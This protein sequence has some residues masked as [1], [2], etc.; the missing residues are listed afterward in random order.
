MHILPDKDTLSQ[1]IKKPLPVN[2][3]VEKLKEKGLRIDNDSKAEKILLST[4]YYYFTGYLIKSKKTRTDC[5]E[6]YDTDLDFDDVYSLIKFD[7]QLRCIF[8]QAIDYI[9]RDI[10]TKIAYYM[11]MDDLDYG[12][13]NYLYTDYF[14]DKLSVQNFKNENEKIRLQ[15]TLNRNHKDF[16]RYYETEYN[17]KVDNSIFVKH[18]NE[19]YWGCLPIWVAVEIMTIGNIKNLY[20][21]VLPNSIKSKISGAYNLSPELFNNYLKGLNIFRNLLAHNVRLYDERTSYT[22]MTNC[23]DP[24]PNTNFIFDYVVILKYLISD[25]DFWNCM[26]ITQ[27]KMLFMELNKKINSDRWGFP[28]NWLDLLIIRPYN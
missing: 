8:L 17:K 6:Y 18:H 2:K 9:E 14:L 25:T 27:L 23:L 13:I 12:S 4:N 24:I 26:I 21:N 5:S 28:S 19:K 3:Q 22:P 1:L 7:M 11:A 15:N 20:G 10:K 16:I